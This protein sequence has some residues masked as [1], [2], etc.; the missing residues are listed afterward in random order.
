M[1]EH[2]YYG[3]AMKTA[4]RRMGNSHGLLIPKPILMQ[5][6]FEDEVEMEVEDGALVIRRVAKSVRAG[7]A[8][9]GKA[10]AAAGD[11]ELVLGEFSNGDDAELEW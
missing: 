7:W 1:L 4:I 10:I 2:C 3:E 8:E 9:A 11:D 6:G 5:L